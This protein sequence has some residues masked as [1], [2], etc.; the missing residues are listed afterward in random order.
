MIFSFVIVDDS[1]CRP[2]EVLRFQGRAA[3]FCSN[4]NVDSPFSEIRWRYV[5]VFFEKGGEVV[6]NVFKPPP[7]L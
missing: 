7:P 3:Q 5:C 1:P 6:G 4:C 2:G